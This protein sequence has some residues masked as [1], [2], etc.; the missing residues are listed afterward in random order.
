ML[1]PAMPALEAPP[2]AIDVQPE[3]ATPVAPEVNAADTALNGAQVQAA[4]GIVQQVAAGQLPRDAAL[5][6]LSAFFNLDAGRAEQVMGSVG[7]GFSPTPAPEASTV[8][9]AE[10]RYADID[11]SPP[12]GARDAAQRG[13][14]LRREYGRGGTAV[15]I[16]RARDLARGADM[17]PDTV[18]RMVSFFA[19]H[20]QNRGDGT[21]MPPSNGYIAWQLWG[22]DAGL[23]WAS[24]VAEQMDARDEEAMSKADAPAPKEDQITGSDVNPEGS[25]AGAGAG[26]DIELDE[27][28]ENAIRNAL[29]RHNEEVGDARSKQAT[30][31]MLRAVW[32]RGAGAFSVS[33]RPGMTRQ[34]WAMARVNA[35]LDIL[36]TGKPENERYIGD[37][38]LLPE[39]HPRSTRNREES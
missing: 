39:D 6:M 19:R 30:M 21:E 13:L 33:H 5:G 35:F 7:R 27:P 29:E 17:S 25:A 14:D 31:G 32:R 9:K 36:R 3:T 1:T 37:N 18:R 38:D 12:E 20:A 2:E 11:F 28:A 4:L 26:R 24:K 8:G 34:Q 16:A 15:G 10:G 23:A 22:G